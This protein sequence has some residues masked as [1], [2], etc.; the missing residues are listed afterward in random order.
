[1]SKAALYKT[2]GG[3]QSSGFVLER[4]DCTVRSFA[5]AADIP[6][7]E[8]HGI[9][10]RSGRRNGHGWYPER[11]LAQAQKD[12]V[13]DFA[14]VPCAIPMYNYTT[15]WPTLGQIIAK[16]PTGRYIVSTHNHAMALIDGTIHDTGLVGLRCRI[17]NIFEVKPAVK[18]L[19]AA[20]QITQTQINDLWARMDALEAKRKQEAR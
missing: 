12:G 6:Y 17:Q 4:R 7:I 18:A 2:D 3:R 5:C 20:P 1:M 11:I 10:K 19:P 15:K 9:A 16:Y 13:L 14:K 8:A